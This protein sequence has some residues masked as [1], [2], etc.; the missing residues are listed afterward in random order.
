M[1]SHP[2]RVRRNYAKMTIRE[3]YNSCSEGM[4][5]PELA[6]MNGAVLNDVLLTDEYDAHQAYWVSEEGI[7]PVT[8][9]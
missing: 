1:P 7:E 8:F 2:D 9:T 6:L 5:T 3:L 4:G